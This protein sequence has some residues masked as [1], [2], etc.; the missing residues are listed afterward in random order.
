MLRYLFAGAVTV[1]MIA[2]GQVPTHGQ[3]REPA[4][5]TTKEQKVEVQ[6]LFRMST[7]TGMPVKNAAGKD[8]GK[9]EDLVIE[10]NS[11]DIRYAALSFGG[12]ASLGDKLFAV[13]WRAM[14]FKFGET[15]SYFVFDVSEEQL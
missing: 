14:S 4:A 2:G 11:G 1:A 6:T 9:I 5:A 12:F 10:L 15:E 3:Q 8:L 7:I 13:P